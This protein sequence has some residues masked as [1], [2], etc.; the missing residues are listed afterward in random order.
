MMRDSEAA[1]KTSPMSESQR[2]LWLS[3]LALREEPMPGKLE[4]TG[5]GKPT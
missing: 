1:S 2:G 3:S 5:W 4:G